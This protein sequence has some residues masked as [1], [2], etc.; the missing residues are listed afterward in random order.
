VP[1]R[2]RVPARRVRVIGRDREIDA[3]HD[4]LLTTDGR[5]VTLTGA[6][7]IGKTTVAEEVARR[8]AHAMD[9]GAA[10]VSLAGTHERDAIA[11]TC[12]E[13][14]ALA[15]QQ[16]SPVQVLTEHLAPRR[17]LLVLDNAEH[18]MPELG[19]L[20]DD[21]LDG[22]PDLRVLV[23]SRLP[24]RIRGE[25]V[26]VLPPLTV[27]D[28]TGRGLH[29]ATAVD[30][31]VERAVAARP[32]FRLDDWGPAVSSI[33]RR[34]DG[35]PLAIELAAAQVAALTPEEIDRLLVTEIDSP[36]GRGDPDDD[37]LMDAA[38]HWSHDLLDEQEQKVFR[39]LAVFAGGWTLEA[40]EHVCAD[41]SDPR[42]IAT[43]LVALVESSLVLRDG[44]DRGGR[45]R[46]LHPVAEYAAERLRAS[47]DE[48]ATSLRHARYYLALIASPGPDWRVCTPEHLDLIAT[49]HDNCLAALQFA[50]RERNASVVLGLDTALLLFW[51][52][53]G[54]LRTGQ[55]RLE[56]A[57]PVLGDE[58]S[59]ER[60]LVL[61]GLAHYSQLLGEREAAWTW[62]RESESA[63]R[64]AGDPVGLR[65]VLGF[66]GDIAA[67]DGSHAVACGYYDR[68]RA[69]AGPDPT[70]LDL[71][72]WHANVGLLALR[73]GD[74][75]SAEREL[76]L[77]A[78]S[79]EEAPEW[80][81][82]H[83]RVRLGAIARRRGDLDAAEALLADALT[84]LRAYR[85]TVE[86]VGCL[87][88]LAAVALARRDG[89]R[90]S[91][92]MACATRL[93]DAT[94]L[95]MTDADR[96][97]RSRDLERARA[98]LRPEAFARA[99]ARGRRLTLDEATTVAATPSRRTKVPSR[100]E[101][102]GGPSGT[103]TPREVQVA[104]LVADGLT[105][106]AVAERLGIA[107]GTARIHV[108]RIL[109][110]LGL[111][112]RVQIATWAVRNREAL[113]A[114]VQS[115]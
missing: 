6:G 76:R 91:T 57:L 41:E 9:D 32:G 64:E 12:C 19:V 18:L 97:Q 79:L 53:R 48:A 8:L 107:Q 77:A 17:A 93:R 83:V 26:V 42:K 40:A 103:L 72:F 16:R 22:C 101:A 67:D 34:L 37:R 70:A 1:D 13:S 33:C 92:L 66:L 21:L 28:A 15:Q 80:Y 3:V 82:A 25:T 87:D 52:V 4:R 60:G 81:Q 10:V 20:V 94:S 69:L 112:S 63:L 38:L 7:G 65:T 89:A 96:E 11:T 46:M 86:A 62:G 58:P 49:E 5:L 110:K 29:S 61:A 84:H 68:A 50:E 35:I 39:R 31:F 59:R 2:P 108:E 55:R 99:W 78:A 54:L 23:T 75:D 24:L 51:R 27:P 105:N 115:R 98:L 14:L 104:A 100:V 71:G 88:E 113:Q 102:P 95:A 36:H 45:F 109:G 90:A 74:L 111:T 43:V 114:H 106:A 44:P 30:L 73:T 47:G 56:A 85:A